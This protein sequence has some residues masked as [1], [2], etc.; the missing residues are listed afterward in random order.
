MSTKEELVAGLPLHI[1]REIHNAL[2]FANHIDHQ[3][4]EIISVGFDLCALIAQEIEDSYIEGY[5]W[6]KEHYS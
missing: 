5:E 3:T 2:D 1:Y 6:A 4:W